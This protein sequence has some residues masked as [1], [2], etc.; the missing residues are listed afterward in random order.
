MSCAPLGE[1]SVASNTGLLFA[2]SWLPVFYSHIRLTATLVSCVYL[3]IRR[4]CLIV[5]ISYLSSSS[6]GFVPPYLKSCYCLERLL[7]HI[8]YY[9]NSSKLKSPY[10]SDEAPDPCY[11]P[12]VG[13]RVMPFGVFTNTTVINHHPLL[14]VLS[15]LIFAQ[16]A[17]WIHVL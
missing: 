1:S 16:G 7:S 17:Y 15:R 2:F 3:Y 12:I 8:N 4:Q 11:A 5:I 6:L 13:R 14:D 10:A 9:C